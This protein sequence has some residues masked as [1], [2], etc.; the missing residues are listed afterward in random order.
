MGN[1]MPP[2]QGGYVPGQSN[3]YHGQV[4]PQQSPPPP[5]L[6]QPHPYG[7]PPPGML[8]AVPPGYGP[9]SRPSSGGAMERVAGGLLLVAALLA[10]VFR[11]ANA[12]SS[13]YRFLWSDVMLALMI[14]LAILTGICALAGMGAR[15]PVLRALAAVAAG[16]LLSGM[17]EAVLGAAQFEFLFE[18]TYWLSIPCALAAFAATLATVVAAAARTASA[19]RGPVPHQYPPQ[20]QPP[21]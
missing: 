13:S 7:A 5:Y 9:A 2:G 15:Y 20:N 8:A 18:D 3:P 19:P 14:L 10:I 16:M 21:R 1:P 11:L 12:F 17:V 4:N 6:G